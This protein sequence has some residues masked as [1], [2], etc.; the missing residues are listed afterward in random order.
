M[1]IKPTEVKALENYQ[2]WIKY[3]DGKE[4][5]IDLSSYAGKGI[6]KLW[7]NYEIFK[8]VHIGEHGEIAWGPEIDLCPDSLYLKLTNKKPDQLFPKLREESINA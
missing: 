1:K 5:V 8:S 3:S 2:I 4:G 7:K 6:F